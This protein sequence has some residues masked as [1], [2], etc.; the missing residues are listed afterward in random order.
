[1]GIEGR[2]RQTVLG[3]LVLLCTFSN[4][5]GQ[6]PLDLN[7]VPGTV[8][9]PVSFDNSQTKM[10]VQ[11]GD[12]HL[13]TDTHGNLPGEYWITNGSRV[14]AHRKFGGDS[15]VKVTFPSDGTYTFHFNGQG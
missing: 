12:Y 3:L 11:A 7:V 5:E 15:I 14:I 9:A 1:M 8:Y 6:V 10:F 4:A 13:A 2:P